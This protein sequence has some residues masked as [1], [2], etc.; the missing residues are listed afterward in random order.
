MELKGAKLSWLFSAKCA[1]DEFQCGTNPGQCILSAYVCDGYPDCSNNAD[2]ENCSGQANLDLFRKHSRIRLDVPYLERWLQTTAQGC[3]KYCIKA[4][5]FTCKSFNY[6]ASKKL[7]I[8]NE[9]NIGL[10]G[11]VESDSQW[12]YYELKSE[13]L[14]CDAQLQC[15]N[16]KC[17]SEEQICDGKYDCENED[18]TDESGCPSQPN[19]QIRFCSNFSMCSSDTRYFFLTTYLFPKLESEV[20]CPFSFAHLELS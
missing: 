17:L 6:Q 18:E 8:L 4:I 9:L 19:I 11:K 20:F 16:G 10:T 3:A 1:S 12:D 7:C 5:D 14:I 2:E 15:R 13:S